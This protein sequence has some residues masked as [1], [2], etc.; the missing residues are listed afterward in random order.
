MKRILTFLQLFT[1]LTTLI[2]LAWFIV[3]I[4]IFMFEGKDYKWI[5]TY[6]LI[7]SFALWALL[8]TKNKVNEDLN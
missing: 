5:S 6:F 1:E 3:D 8:N 7:I 4:I 2:S